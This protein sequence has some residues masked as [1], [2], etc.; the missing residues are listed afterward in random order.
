M[1][2]ER[3]LKKIKYNLR[4]KFWWRDYDMTN[5]IRNL[6]FLEMGGPGIKSWP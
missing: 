2:T 6:G 1:F 3:D 4:L 5:R